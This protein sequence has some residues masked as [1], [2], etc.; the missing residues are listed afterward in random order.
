MA[1]EDAVLE[2]FLV[3]KEKVRILNIFHPKT[4]KIQIYFTGDC[5]N[6]NQCMGDLVCGESGNCPVGF[7]NPLFNC[8][9]R[10]P[11]DTTTTTPSPTNDSNGNE[12]FNV[13]NID[14]NGISHFRT[15]MKRDSVK[16]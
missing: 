8:C 7:L 6:D 13:A 2:I 14:M 5:D 4:R 1:L 15:D 12:Y 3:G 11:T 9:E 16:C 10:P